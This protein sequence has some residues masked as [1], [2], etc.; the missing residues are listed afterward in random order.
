MQVKPPSVYCQPIV[1]A[2]RRG[3]PVEGVAEDVLRIASL[4]QRLIEMSEAVVV[5]KGSVEGCLTLL[6]AQEGAK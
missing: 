2:L 4:P 1:A 6:I 3:G 5:V